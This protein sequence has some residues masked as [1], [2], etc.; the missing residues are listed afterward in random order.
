MSWDAVAHK[1]FRDAIRSRWLWGLS[2][3]FVGFIG[4]IPAVVYGAFGDGGGSS[5]ALFGASGGIP[6]VGLSLSYSGILAFIVAF[7]A[8]V[9]S[10]GSLI[11]ERESGT[12]KLLLSLPHSRR[13]VVVGKF[14]GRTVVV[15][16]PVLAGFLV[17]IVVMIATST[18]VGFGT[19]LSQI[20]L[21]VVVAAAFVAIGVGVSASSTSNRQ[22]TVSIFGLYF[23]LAFLWSLVARGFPALLSEVAKRLPGVSAPEALTVV[24]LRMVI[25]YL[26]PLRAYETLVAGLYAD[27][28]LAA[29]L[30]KAGFQERLVL[31]NALQGQDL[32]AYFQGWFLLLVL[33]AWVAGPLALGYYVFRGEDL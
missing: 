26:N 11:D 17:A 18:T 33:L 24:K 21:T 15:A 25:K 20:A 13:D 31:G 32:P 1:D 27:S 6:L 10:H 12:L 9:S 16:L 3:L 28:A 22:A 5:E 4:G 30:V 29:R 23:L 7:I 19:L 8:L 14:L 2:L